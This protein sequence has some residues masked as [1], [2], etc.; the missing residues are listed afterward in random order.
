[1]AGA[2]TTGDFG[3]MPHRTFCR[4]LRTAI[5]SPSKTVEPADPE[6]DDWFRKRDLTRQTPKWG[7][8]DCRVASP[9][10]EVG[11]NEIARLASSPI[12]SD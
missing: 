12:Q 3:D 4:H 1:M 5:E 2:E 6:Q 9:G 8:E 7:I 10:S 11:G